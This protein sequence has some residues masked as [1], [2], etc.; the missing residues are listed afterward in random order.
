METRIEQF[1]QQR[2]LLF[3]IAYRMLGSAMDAEDMVQETFLRWQEASDDEIQSPKAYLSTIVTRLSIDHLRSA[4]KQREEYIG[5]WLPEPILTT[6]NT[7]MTDTLELTE[8]L[9]MA[10]LVLLESLSPIE[11]AVYLLREVFGYEYG[12][13][14]RIV[15]K[16]Q[17]NCR[18][19]ARRAKEHI[20]AKR[21]RFDATREQQEE[22]TRRFIVAC[23]SGDLQA[24]LSVLAPDVVFQ[25]DSGGKVSAARKP[26]YGAEKVAR[27]VLGIL[28]LLPSD[29]NVELASVNA[30]PA[31][32]GYTEGRPFYVTVLDIAEGHIQGIYNVLN[33]DKL[34]NLPPQSPVPSV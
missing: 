21:P 10:F 28:K 11:R 32:I 6:E 23:M 29:A 7:A 3:G 31:I 1:N 34:V 20:A 33:P 16:S 30:Q 13:I 5:P 24:L 4:Q 8:S 27:A 18:Q 9:S 15:G 26:I 19:I 22:V 2:S 12:E 17:A 14:E 25:A